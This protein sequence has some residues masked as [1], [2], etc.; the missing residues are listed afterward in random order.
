M[1]MPILWKSLSVKKV[2]S[3]FF[4]ESA[5]HLLQRAFVLKSSQPR[6]AESLIAFSSPGDEV[7]KRGVEGKLCALVR[8]DGADEIASVNRAP[9]HTLKF[10]LIFGHGRNPGDSGIHAGLTHLA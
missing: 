2:G 10:R 5:W 3:R 4:S 7:I 8:C 1:P 6:L 9:E